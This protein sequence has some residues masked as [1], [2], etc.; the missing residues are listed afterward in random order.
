MTT[1]GLASR[2]TPRRRRSTAWSRHLV[3]IPLLLLLLYPLA[4]LL[5]AS[6]KPES[7]IFT[8]TG[9]L[10]I[11]PTLAN[12]VTGWTNAGR[13][14]SHFMA[15]SIAIAAL[16]TIGTVISASFA[17]YAFAR[18]KFPFRRTLFVAM[19]ATMMLPTQV[20]LIPQF[21]IFRELGWVDSFLPLIVPRALAHDGFFVFLFTQ[22]VRSL[23]RELDEAARIDG[24]GPIQTFFQIL[25]PL[26]SPAI[27]TAS[28][29]SFI[30]AYDDFFAQLIYLSTPDLYTVP[31]ALRVFIDT[32]GGTSSFG[33]MLAMSVISLVPVTV[34][35]LVLQRRL[36]QGIAAIGLK[37]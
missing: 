15:N 16:S 22:F 9:L 33:G 3:L 2:A 34:V 21:L 13:P 5:S 28:V 11:D 10:P 25:L 29:F 14:F 31:M 23:P 4:W 37:G 12:Y 18:L 35:F 1:V 17:G 6:I 32:T 20:T 24:C 26:L 19:L 30:W 8:N 7:E 27:I 36:T